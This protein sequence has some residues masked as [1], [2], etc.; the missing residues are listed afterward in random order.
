[1]N[2]QQLAEIISPIHITYDELSQ[3]LL[4]S[5]NTQISQTFAEGSI[6][7]VEVI[8]FANQG[9]GIVLNSNEFL[10]LLSV[11]QSVCD[12][13]NEPFS[14]NLQND[15]V[16]VLGASLGSIFVNSVNTQGL[17]YGFATFLKFKVV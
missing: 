12:I 5:Y 13:A 6:N 2:K 11:S 10:I 1:M 3:T 4:S 16:A 8:I 7:F 15:T 9:F 17:G 14:Y